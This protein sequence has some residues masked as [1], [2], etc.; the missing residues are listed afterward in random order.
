MHTL[1][2]LLAWFAAR[3]GA[4]VRPAGV[5]GRH[6][7]QTR[8]GADRS[9]RLVPLPEDAPET[10]TSTSL[11]AYWALWAAVALVLLILAIGYI[12]RRWKVGATVR[13]AWLRWSSAWGRYSD[14]E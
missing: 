6:A 7:F 3:A 5:E 4:T 9:G 2:R 11:E 12:W 10:E 13:P 14:R 8:A 1:V